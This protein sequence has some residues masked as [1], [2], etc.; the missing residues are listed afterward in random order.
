MRSQR[1]SC[2]WVFVCVCAYV[3]YIKMP[4]CRSHKI[5]C[6]TNGHNI[7]IRNPVALCVACCMSHA[8]ASS[9]QLWQLCGACSALYSNIRVRRATI[10]ACVCV[11]LCSIP[12]AALPFNCTYCMTLTTKF[13]R[14]RISLPCCSARLQHVFFFYCRVFLLFSFMAFTL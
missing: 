11:C 14:K 10:Y 13:W 9:A 1:T 4:K 2:M 5:Y 6:H 8:V 7:C 3:K 12:S